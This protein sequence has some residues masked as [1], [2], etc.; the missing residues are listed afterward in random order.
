MRD[1]DLWEQFDQAYK[2]AQINIDRMNL[3]NARAWFNTMRD[4]ADKLED[5]MTSIQIKNIEEQL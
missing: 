5:S 3:E 2:Y 1:S 4:I